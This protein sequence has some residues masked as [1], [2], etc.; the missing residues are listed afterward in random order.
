MLTGGTTL[1]FVS[2]SMETVKSMCDHA[3]WLENG[4]VKGKGLTD[5]VCDRY[6]MGA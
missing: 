4:R 6:M 5:E 3:L 1:L 2:H